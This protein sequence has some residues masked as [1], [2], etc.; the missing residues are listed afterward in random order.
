M[1]VLACLNAGTRVTG[2]RTGGVLEC[3]DQ[4]YQCSAC[5]NAGT[6]VPAACLN[7]GTRVTGVRTGGVLECRD[8]GYRCS[9]RRRA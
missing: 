7:A 4:G 6:I 8:Q 9:Y 5:L 1:F 3:R 2:V